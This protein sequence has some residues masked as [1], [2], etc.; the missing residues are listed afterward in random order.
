[1]LSNMP[2]GFLLL[3]SRGRRREPARLR[4]SNELVLARAAAED[5]VWGAAQRP[6]PDGLGAHERA[7][8]HLRLVEAIEHANE[9]ACREEVAVLVPER[10]AD[11]VEPVI[12][13]LDAQ[14]SDPR[15]A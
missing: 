5:G 10:L 12:V 4:G 9:I 6:V 8:A 15:A 2:M 11:V 7:Q 3:T 14:R 13:G 1:M